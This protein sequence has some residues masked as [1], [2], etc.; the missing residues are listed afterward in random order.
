MTNQILQERYEIQRQ[1]GKNPGR[2]TL[3][4]KVLETQELVVVKLLNFDIEFD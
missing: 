1:L 4:A 3:L 2:K